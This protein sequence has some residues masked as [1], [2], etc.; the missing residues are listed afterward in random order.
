MTN[1]IT[2]QVR[3]KALQDEQGNWGIVA[4]WIDEIWGHECAAF[5]PGRFGSKEEA[6]GSIQRGGT[7]NEKI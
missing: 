5:L 6:W 4:I 3:F 7:I 2:N 1:N